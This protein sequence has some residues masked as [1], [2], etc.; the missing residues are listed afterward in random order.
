MTTRLGTDILGA[1]MEKISHIQNSRSV[2]DLKRLAH[3][4]GK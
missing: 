2:S 1:K 3:T 4:N